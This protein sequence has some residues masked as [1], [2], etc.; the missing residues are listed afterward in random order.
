[1][2]EQ[3]APEDD[4]KIRVFNLDPATA[5]AATVALTLRGGLPASAT[6]QANVTTNSLIA[7]APGPVMVQLEAML[8]DMQKQL[9]ASLQ[10]Q[11]RIHWLKSSDPV[12]AVKVLQALL[13]K[14]TFAADAQARSIAAT[15]TAAEIG[16]AH[17]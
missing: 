17:V 11:T 12:A 10:R 5:D 13:P 2:V 16:R 7:I 3:F 15:A 4:Q 6:V 1:M 8:G 9:P 14:A